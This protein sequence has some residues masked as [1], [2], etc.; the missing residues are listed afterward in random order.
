VKQAQTH[1]LY[2]LQYRQYFTHFIT[3]IMKMMSIIN[4]IIDRLFLR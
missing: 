2:K 1:A 4:K 3:T